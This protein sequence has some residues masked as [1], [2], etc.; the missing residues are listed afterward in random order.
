ML[1]IYF[2][3]VVVIVLFHVHPVELTWLEITKALLRSFTRDK[4]KMSCFSSFPC[5]CDPITGCWAP[6]GWTCVKWEEQFVL[7]VPESWWYPPPLPF[8]YVFYPSTFYHTRRCI[9]SLS[10]F[11]FRSLLLFFTCFFFILFFQLK[12]SLREN[13]CLDQGPDT[14]NVPIMYLCHGMTPQV[15]GRSFYSVLF[16]LFYLFKYMKNKQ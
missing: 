1:Y 10:Y 13:L 11:H 7:I 6:L 2:V 9:R 15:S 8:S 16:F 5:F 12:N 4:I 3:N 14:D